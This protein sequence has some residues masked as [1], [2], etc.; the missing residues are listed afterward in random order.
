MLSPLASTTLS[1]PQVQPSSRE[2]LATVWMA[3]ES[4]AESRRP[5]ANA[6][7]DASAART[8]AGIRKV[9]YPSVPD[10]NG[11]DDVQPWCA[12]TA[13]AAG[14]KGSPSAAAVRRVVPNLRIGDT[15]RLLVGEL[16]IGWEDL[17]H[18]MSDVPCPDNLGSGFS[19]VKVR[20][21]GFRMME[22]H[23]SYHHGNLR[24][25]LLENADRVLEESGPDERP[26]GSWPA[27]PA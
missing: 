10:V 14:V 7:S 19:F 22:A 25:V 26:C 20:W 21:R 24:G 23:T 11:T 1:R 16:G 8:T 3:P 2:V 15:L 12:G 6:T 5:S 17:R 4:P 13:V 27:T 18:G 9:S